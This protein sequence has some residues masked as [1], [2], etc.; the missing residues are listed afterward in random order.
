MSTKLIWDNLVTYSLQI[1]LLVGLAAFVPAVLRL[2]L[3][4]AKLVYWHILLVTCLVLPL[5]QPWRHEV[6]AGEVQ[7]SSVVTRVEAAKP[8]PRPALP[9]SEMALLLLATGAAVRLAWLGV[10]F[11]RLRSYRRSAVPLGR[12]TACPAFLSGE[13]VSPVTFGWRHPVVLLPARFPDLDPRM[14]DA[15]LCHEALHVERGDWLITVTEE[16]VRAVFW[17]HPAIWWLLG[18]IQLARE[19]AVDRE[20]ID[21]TQ[22]RE[23]YVDA[24]LAI[25][26]AAP[27]ADL[28]PAPLFLRKRHLKQRVVSILKEV[29]MSKTRWI[30]GLAAAV[31]ILAAAC[32]LVTGTFPLAAAPQVV[33]DAP[34]VSVD[35]GAGPLLHRAPVAYPEAA[36]KNGVQGTVV[37][38]AT[39]DA[40]GN[41]TDAQVLSGPAELRRAA[42]ESVLQW[43]FKGDAAGTTR[44]VSITFQLPETAR[45]AETKTTIAVMS[46]ANPPSQEAQTKLAMARLAQATATMQAR[47]TAMPLEG[48]TVS[49]IN[50][51]GLSDAMKAELLAKLPVREGDTMSA[52]SLAKM[53]AA[54]K[55]FDEHL[56]LSTSLGS[57]NDAT[58]TITAPNAEAVSD[59]KKIQIG[60][61]IQQTKLIRQPHP[62]Y[63]PEAK[64]A[65]VQGVVQL[66]AVIAA[67]GT[68]KDLQ[69]VSGHP[70]LAEA[71]MEAVRQ[72][73][74]QP[75]LLNGE[76]VEVSTRIDVNFTLTQ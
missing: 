38:S 13:V 57:A 16:V 50:V 51:V 44:Q 43:H 35:T 72:W 46:M 6:V 20:V 30:S 62:I 1:G 56:R 55:E 22:A 21:R 14:Q 49:S 42:L 71:A 10:G 68:V 52:D 69:L 29:R 54:V 76:P 5:V 67:D 15:I 27:T 48:R 33:N 26:G 11:W 70:L 60:G 9:R 40:S 75:T 39:L 7:V 37:V 18:E 2:R 19:Q 53:A 31:G 59:V 61:A 12:P 32:W 47:K 73:V 8:A 24:L 23:D 25:A 28:A 17:F 66:Q 36:R 58:M 65:R 4:R 41:V 3:P 74:Y 63:P 34:G 45:P 64:V